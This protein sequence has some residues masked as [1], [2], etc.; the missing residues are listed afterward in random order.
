MTEPANMKSKGP[1]ENSILFF[2]FPRRHRLPV[3]SLFGGIISSASQ[4]GIEAILLRFGSVGSISSILSIGK[5]EVPPPEQPVEAVRPIV[6]E[7]IDWRFLRW[8]IHVVASPFQLLSTIRK[9]RPQRI[10]VRDLPHAAMAA[11]AAKIFGIPLLYVADSRSWIDVERPDPLTGKAPKRE[12]SSFLRLLRRLKTRA[13]ILLS[14]MVIVPSQQVRA[15]FSPSRPESGDGDEVIVSRFP[16]LLVEE[17]PDAEAGRL[18]LLR[19]H[20]FAEDSFLV[21]AD[22]S[23]NDQRTTE[24]FIRTIHALDHPQAVLLLLGEMED[25]ERIRS[26]IIGF[27]LRDYIHLTGWLDSP[28]SVYGHADLMIS[29][30]SAAGI[31]SAA[32]GAMR[33]GIP[34]V[35]FNDIDGR[36]TLGRADQ[37]YQDQHVEHFSSWLRELISNPH[38]MEAVKAS[39]AARGRDLA[40]IE[41]EKMLKVLLER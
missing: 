37:L 1:A 16:L 19:Q 3:G 26:L 28:A 15:M 20:S 12:A 4:L 11:P 7:R 36:E 32:L 29:L 2:F 39:T 27:G 17:A 14:T 8:L 38:R 13:V 34:V 40:A 10:V 18:N 23:E 31:G 24:L 41:R 25:R 6:A 33:L 5:S 22:V 35:A 9:H 30:P 21:V